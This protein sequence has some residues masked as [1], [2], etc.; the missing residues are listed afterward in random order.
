MPYA[1]LARLLSHLGPGTAAAALRMQL[2]TGLADSAGPGAALAWQQ[3]LHDCL[4]QAPARV[5]V[6]DDLQFA[7]PAST[8][9]LLALIEAE[10]LAHLAWVLAMRPCGHAAMRQGDAPPAA[11]RRRDALQ[12]SRRLQLLRL[13]PLD[14]GSM[15]L[16][17]H[18]LGRSGDTVQALAERLV[19]HTGGNPFFALETLKQLPADAGGQAALPRPEPVLDFIE[20]R[21]RTLSED[22]LSIARVAAIA[23]PDFGAE[24][25]AAVLGRSALALADAWSE[26]EAAQVFRDCGFAHDL[27]AEAAL[28]GVP[29]AVARPVHAAVAAWLETQDGAPARVALHWPAAGQP[30]RALPWLARAAELAHRQ[31][32]P[33]EEG[34]FLALWAE[35]E[36]PLDAGRAADVLLRLVRV[37]VEAGGMAAS[38]ATLERVLHLA[39]SD[40]QRLQVLNLLAESHLNRLMPAASARAAEQALALARA[41]GDATAAAESVVHWHR[42]LC[43]AG[44]AGEAESL[45]QSHQGWMATTTLQRVDLVSDRGSVLDRMARAREARQWHARALSRAQ[46]TGRPI[47]AAVVLG[48]LAQSLVMAGEPAQAEAV[49]DRAE[50]LSAR[51]DGLHAASD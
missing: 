7:D 36:E 1:T 21:L 9:M 29:T 40:V 38:M 26:L 37:Q 39:G 34:D 31:W 45:W 18:D 11:Q 12:Q 51:H 44:R 17:L 22:A 6:V 50:A 16:L 14:A 43:M 4:A 35:I 33:V 30:V 41:L 48:N 42:A 49:F 19:R 23:G 47:E 13:W 25:A 8:E 24:L 3:A 32:R 20:R 15:A 46:A 28:Q 2:S 27:V 5:V 10:A